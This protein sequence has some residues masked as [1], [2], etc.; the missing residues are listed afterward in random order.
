MTIATSDHAA[1][2]NGLERELQLES[3]TS[4]FQRIAFALLALPSGELIAWSR[5]DRESA[6]ALADCIGGI[7]AAARRFRSVA[8]L[9]EQSADRALVAMCMRADATELLA[10]AHEHH[11]IEGA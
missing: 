9:M 10:A 6:E 2:V 5:Q 8:E 4:Q 11:R 7:R 3:G 1:L